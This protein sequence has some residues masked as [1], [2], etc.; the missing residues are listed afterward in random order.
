MK[1]AGIQDA[2]E[3]FM[4]EQFEEGVILSTKA[5]WRGDEYSVELFPD[6]A[7]R[8]LWNVGSL[9]DSPG[10]ILGIPPL[11]DDEWDDDGEHYF[12]LVEDIVR[13]SLTEKAAE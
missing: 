3:A 9:Y 4:A 8:L 12:G 1:N 7:Y 10:L 6:G 5:S 13:Q 11:G 2:F